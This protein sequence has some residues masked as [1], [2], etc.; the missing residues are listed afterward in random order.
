MRVA[1]CGLFR[2]M[3][4]INFYLV[5]KVIFHFQQKLF[6]NIYQFVA[7]VRYIELVDL[8]RFALN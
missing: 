8:Y 1:R 4:E 3:S 2:L 6:L 7:F 5:T